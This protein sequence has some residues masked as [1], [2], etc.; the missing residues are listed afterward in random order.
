MK[1]DG[2]RRIHHD[3]SSNQENPAPYVSPRP[4]AVRSVFTPP[5]RPLAAV[6][7]AG[8]HN[9]QT[10]RRE[11][12]STFDYFLPPGVAVNWRLEHKC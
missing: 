4:L 12:F 10:R 6:P 1:T 5:E 7:P 8:G 9:P 3:Q 11:I 2:Y